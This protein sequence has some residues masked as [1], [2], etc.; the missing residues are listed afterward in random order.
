MLPLFSKRFIDFYA[1]RSQ[2]WASFSN[3]FDG[4]YILKLLQQEI[5]SSQAHLICLF[6]QVELHGSFFQGGFLFL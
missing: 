5:R 6:D 2:S 1:V 3:I 4:L